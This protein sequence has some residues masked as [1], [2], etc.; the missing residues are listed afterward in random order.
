ME[1]YKKLNRRKG[2][3]KGENNNGSQKHHRISS[4]NEDIKKV[5]TLPS[6]GVRQ[7]C[8]GLIVFA[9]KGR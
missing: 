8:R 1:G 2:I 4:G 5:A 7:R 3:A 6:M 9:R